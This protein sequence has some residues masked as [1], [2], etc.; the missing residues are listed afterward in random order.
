MDALQREKV[1]A[2]ENPKI[3]R[4]NFVCLGLGFLEPIFQWPD[5]AERSVGVMAATLTPFV[6]T[7]LIART[8]S[9]KFRN[10]SYPFGIHA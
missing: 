7:N 10:P 4:C 8:M 1:C 9:D 5:V 2:E 6:E 3:K